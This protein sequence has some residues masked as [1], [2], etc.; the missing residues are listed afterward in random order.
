MDA[1][2]PTTHPRT[3]DKVKGTDVGSGDPLGG[4]F[5]MC[6]HG[7]DRLQRHNKEGAYLG[8]LDEGDLRLQTHAHYHGWGYEHSVSGGQGWV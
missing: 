6:Q 4:S 1:R 2:V 8:E 7:P 3:Y 5:S